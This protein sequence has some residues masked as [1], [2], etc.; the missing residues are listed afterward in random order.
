MHV[1]SNDFVHKFWCLLS[2]LDAATKE[3]SLQQLR[4]LKKMGMLCKDAILKKG[5][6]CRTDAELFVISFLAW[7]D[8][9]AWSAVNTEE[10]HRRMRKIQKEFKLSWVNKDNK[11]RK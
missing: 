10:L 5:G 3:Q 7:H 2:Q 8:N 9:Y 4:E 11:K 1:K 6:H